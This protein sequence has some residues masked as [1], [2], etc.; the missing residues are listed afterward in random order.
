LLD[1]YQKLFLQL[2]NTR[3]AAKRQKIVREAVRR[4]PD[5]MFFDKLCD[6]V[7]NNSGALDNKEKKT[8]AEEIA[9]QLDEYLADIKKNKGP[10]EQIE[11]RYRYKLAYWIYNNSGRWHGL[12]V[13]YAF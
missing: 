13:L 7:R 5:G 8:V 3:I 2:I 9:S 6:V 10:S 1:W 11:E 12:N 4:V